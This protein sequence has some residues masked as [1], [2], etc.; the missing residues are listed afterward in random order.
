MTS[1]EVLLQ[2]VESA[3]VDANS[4]DTPHNGLQNKSEG[5]KKSE[6]RAVRYCLSWVLP[7]EDG[8]L[9]AST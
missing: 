7:K 8:D 1:Q 5:G 3:E 2:G 6:T 4:R 9:H